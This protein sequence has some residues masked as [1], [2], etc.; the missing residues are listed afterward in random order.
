MEYI[1]KRLANEVTPIAFDGE[2]TPET[3]PE[4][5]RN[6]NEA[7]IALYPWT[8]KYPDTFKAFARVGWN[9]SGLIVLM[10]ADENPILK[11]VTEISTRQCTDSCM[12]FFFI[13]QPE[14]DDRYMNIEINAGGVPYVGFGA[15][16]GTRVRFYELVPGMD[17][18]ASEHKG[19][20][21]AI[22]YRIPV[23]FTEE[24]CGFAPASG[25]KMKGNFYKCSEN[26]HPHF[27]TWNPV[28]APKPDFHRPECFG[29]LV[30]E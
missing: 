10:Y 18:S 1:V 7:E 8:E 14:K 11:N 27:G 24:L 29:D 20:Y 15:G 16:R 28:V 26:I 19:K 12:E 13:P 6:L 9:E 4:A 25:M 5:F 17:I 3:M 23:T 21:W 22:S 30:L 2:F